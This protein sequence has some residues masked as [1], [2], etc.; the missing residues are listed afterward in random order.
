MKGLSKYLF[1]MLIVG[2]SVALNVSYVQSAVSATREVY[3]KALAPLKTAEDN[4]KAALTEYRSSR[5]QN[6]FISKSTPF[7]KQANEAVFLDINILEEAAKN[8]LYL[9]QNYR[10]EV[11]TTVQK[12]R[13]SIAPQKDGISGIN[14]LVDLQYYLI[15]MQNFRIQLLTDTRTIS[16]RILVERSKAGKK[17]VENLL[18]EVKKQA[19]E[20][21]KDNIPEIANNETE[22]NKNLGVAQQ[23]IDASEAVIGKMVDWEN[24][25]ALHNQ[26]RNLTKE[27]NRNIVESL[28]D[29]ESI[30]ALLKT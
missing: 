15:E 19:A 22:I 5:D 30:L 25:D 27:A 13:D 8:D 26:V 14:N 28:T 2:L 20:L 29:L 17:K 9:P 23:N 12:Y 10:D 1:F 3:Q 18:A 11:N 7:L 16:A 24:A 4:Y 6:S 21:S